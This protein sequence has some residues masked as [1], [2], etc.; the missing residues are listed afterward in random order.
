MYDRTTS[1]L[2]EKDFAFGDDGEVLF[3]SNPFGEGDQFAMPTKEGVKRE[4]EKAMLEGMTTIVKTLGINKSS[5]E[6]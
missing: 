1:R 4:N 6:D 2:A 3:E 5:N